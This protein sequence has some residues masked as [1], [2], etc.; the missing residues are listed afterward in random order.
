LVHIKA[1][2]GRTVITPRVGAALVGYFNRPGPSTGIHDDLNARV[3]VLD[4]G[5]TAIA[6]CSVELCWLAGANVQAIR[7]A[8]ADRC[9]LT[10]ENIFVFATH[11][12]S[13]PASQYESD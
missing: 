12:H 1:G 3:V 13:G 4:D 7:A 9:G 6:L 8:A 10:P 2:V 5:D 11:T